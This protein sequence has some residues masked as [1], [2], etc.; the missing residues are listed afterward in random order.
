MAF[1]TMAFQRSSLLQLSH[2][3]FALVV[4][5]RQQPHNYESPRVI[6]LGPWVSD[7]QEEQKVLQVRS[8][9][10]Y[11]YRVFCTDGYGTE[12]AYAGHGC[13]CD[14]VNALYLLVLFNLNQ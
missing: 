5:S 11:T 7:F 14:Y 4:Q 1:Q 6:F 3:I 8:E 9:A 2:H 13:F 10:L 12:K